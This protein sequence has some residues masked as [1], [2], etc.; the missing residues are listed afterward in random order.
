MITPD[1][2]DSPLYNVFTRTWWQRNPAWPRGL[3]PHMGRKRYLRKGVTWTEARAIA[4]EY[5]Q[6]HKPGRLSR[7]A[8]IEQCGA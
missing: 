3:E 4:Q 7:K 6:T 2:Q 1:A 8:E 5:N